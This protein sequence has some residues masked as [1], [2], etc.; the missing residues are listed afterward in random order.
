M[1][2]IEVPVEPLCLLFVPVCLKHEEGFVRPAP[3][4]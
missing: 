4:P 1:E 2:A 3:F